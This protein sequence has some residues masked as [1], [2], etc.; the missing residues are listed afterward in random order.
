MGN[1]YRMKAKKL[2]G[3]PYIGV[4]FQALETLERLYLIQAR[5]DLLTD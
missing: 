2:I 3:D 5:V 4:C 1:I